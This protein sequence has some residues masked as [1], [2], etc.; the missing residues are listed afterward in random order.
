MMYAVAAAG[1]PGVGKALDILQSEIDKVLA[2][3]GC[4]R[5]DELGPQQLRPR[6][7]VPTLPAAAPH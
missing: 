3:L 7:P 2:Q 4:A 6:S 5:F 1:A